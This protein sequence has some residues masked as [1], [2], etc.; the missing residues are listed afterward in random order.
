VSTDINALED[1]NEIIDVINREG[2]FFRMA[3]KKKFEELGCK[4]EV[5][6][7]YSLQNYIEE[8]GTSKSADIFAKR[9][10]S[11]PDNVELNFI[12]E[13]KKSYAQKNKWIFFK[14][15]TDKLYAWNI[16]FPTKGV[17]F[18]LFNKFPSLDFP[19]CYDQ[20]VIKTV[21]RNKSKSGRK[22]EKDTKRG[23]LT[24][25]YQASAEVSNALYG[26]KSN[27]INRLNEIDSKLWEYFFKYIPKDNWYIPLVITNAELNISEFEISNDTLK[28]G[29]IKEDEFKL[30]SIPWLIFEYPLPYYLQIQED[31]NP[32]NSTP[33]EYS[34]FIRKLP[35]IFL[36]STK[37]DDFIKNIYRAAAPNAAMMG[38]I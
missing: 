38:R 2:I 36:N 31:Q 32:K 17:Y 22:L 12:I 25:I 28:D 13:C 24:Q 4:C 21:N 16:N 10:F 7:P 14:H 18:N 35:I 5:E 11:H 34:S 8:K 23:N 6:Y 37:I 27:Y 9:P 33:I 19:V 29:K 20:I 26:I 1:K 3:V 30:E 15:K